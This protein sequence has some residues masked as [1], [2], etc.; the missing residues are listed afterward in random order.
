MSK[1]IFFKRTCLSILLCASCGAYADY[2]SSPC[3]NP[4]LS[5]SETLFG[6]IT[7]SYPQLFS[8]PTSMQTTVLNVFV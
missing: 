1:H 3:S 8:S 4:S 5:Q 2:N 7:Q 6:K